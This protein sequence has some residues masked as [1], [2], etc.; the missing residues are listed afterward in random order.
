MAGELTERDREILEVAITTRRP[1]DMANRIA[2]MR[3]AIKESHFYLRLFELL[4]TE[5]ALAA[6]P[7]GV[8]R[9]NRLL[10]ARNSIRL[11]E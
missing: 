10:T 11:G 8:K 3:P 5:A 7:T 9:L 4:Q 1:G 6:Y 2:A